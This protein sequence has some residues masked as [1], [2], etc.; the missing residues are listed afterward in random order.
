M[1]PKKKSKKSGTARMRELGKVSVIIWL[2]ADE[3]EQL[4]RVRGSLRRAE[5]AKHVTGNAVRERLQYEK[6]R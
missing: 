2:T 4:D 6:A 5:F 1:Q 3:A